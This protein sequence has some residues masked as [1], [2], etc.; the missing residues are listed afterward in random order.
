MP[1]LG[2]SAAFGGNL[3]LPKLMHEFNA[4]IIARSSSIAGVRL[5]KFWDIRNLTNLAHASPMD[6]V[7]IFEDLIIKPCP[8][9]TKCSTGDN[10]TSMSLF[11]AEWY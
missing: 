2:G 6:S 7:E 3:R 8:V 11:V 9:L 10:I 5:Q 1:C 4:F